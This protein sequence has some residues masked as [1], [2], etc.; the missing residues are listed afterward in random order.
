LAWVSSQ[1]DPGIIVCRALRGKMGVIP[2]AEDTEVIRRVACLA[3]HCMMCGISTDADADVKSRECS[4]AGSGGNIP[5][6]RWETDPELASI[7]PRTGGSTGWDKK[8]RQPGWDSDPVVTGGF[9]TNIADVEITSCEGDTAGCRCKLGWNT[10]VADVE[11]TSCNDTAGC[12]SKLGWDTNVADVEI[13]SC[14]DTAGCRRKLGWDPSVAG[15]EIA[16]HDDCG[17]ARDSNVAG[18]EIT[19]CDCDTQ[20]SRREPGWSSSA[21]GIEIAPFNCDTAGRGA[22]PRGSGVAGIEFTTDVADIEITGSGFAGEASQAPFGNKPGFLYVSFL[23]TEALLANSQGQTDIRVDHDSADTVKPPS[24]DRTVRTTSLAES[25]LDATRPAMSAGGEEVVREPIVLRGAMAGR[26][27]EKEIQ[28]CASSRSVLDQHEGDLQPMR[29]RECFGH[30]RWAE[31]D[32]A[33]RLGR[34]PPYGCHRFGMYDA[35]TVASLAAQLL[36]EWAVGDFA[37]PPSELVRI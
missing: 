7:I 21:A 9:S 15:V 5:P 14:D 19:S 8:V 1:A 22:R 4:T 2:N 27:D 13:T 29:W 6:P 31:E 11:I 33:I 16:P 34:P 28:G 24:S 12:R 23:S 10:S 26:V 25:C 35:E 20:G 3:L 37:R 18:I 17:T 30:E 32:V 36:I